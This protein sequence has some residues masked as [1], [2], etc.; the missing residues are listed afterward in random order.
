LKVIIDRFEGDYAVC[1]NEDR[2]M[3]DILSSKLPR[4]AQV[5]DILIIEGSTIILDIEGTKSR[6]KEIDDLT[7]D[8]WV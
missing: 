4:E 2:T 5:G 8:L 7:K 3:V 1:E 6:K